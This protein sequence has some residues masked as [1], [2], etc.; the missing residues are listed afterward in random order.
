[1]STHNWDGNTSDS[2]L[3]QFLEKRAFDTADSLTL[4]LGSAAA[5]TATLDPQTYPPQKDLAKL[6]K[7]YIFA[8]SAVSCFVQPLVSSVTKPQFYNCKSQ[9]AFL[10][11][12]S[13]Y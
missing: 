3:E 12:A 13:H 11:L 9:P 2:S 10:N 8:S 4:C 5:V 7:A 6:G 1:M